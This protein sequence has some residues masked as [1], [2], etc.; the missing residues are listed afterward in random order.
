LNAAPPAEASVRTF[1][2]GDSPGGSVDYDLAAALKVLNGVYYGNCAVP[3]AGK[4]AI[5]F[6]PNGRVKRVAVLRGDYDP[7]TTECITERFGSAHMS[8][9]RGG[10]QSVTAEIVA[11]R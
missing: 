4:L 2:T 3:S 11:T 9:F 5:T 6:A 1:G 10:D 8:P 7:A